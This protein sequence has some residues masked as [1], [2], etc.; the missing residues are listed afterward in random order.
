MADIM[1]P[2]PF[3][4]LMTWILTENKEKGS[5]FGVAKQVHHTTGKALPIFDEKIETPYGPAAGPNSQL[6]QNIN[7]FAALYNGGAEAI[8]DHCIISISNERSSIIVC[9]GI[10]EI[11]INNTKI[12]YFGIG[13]M[14]ERCTFGVGDAVKT[15]YG[16]S[17]SF[18][19]LAVP[20]ITSHGLPESEA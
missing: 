9:I 19:M 7:I 11:A 8:I 18:K 13:L 14:E 10:L 17:V 2:I 5:I 12:G 15:A 3:G 1:R 6:A 20:P 16:V 4:Q